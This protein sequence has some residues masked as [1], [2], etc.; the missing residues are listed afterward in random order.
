MNNR[1]RLNLKWAMQKL[2]KKRPER[3][4]GFYILGGWKSKLGAIPFLCFIYSFRLVSILLWCSNCYM[5]LE[6]KLLVEVFYLCSAAWENYRACVVVVVL[7]YFSIFYVR[8]RDFFLVLFK[9]MKQK[10]YIMKTT[11]YV[12][13]VRENLGL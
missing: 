5:L 13:E 8:I 12:R 11:W 3:N 9:W 7:C 4:V 2:W 6:K 10:Y 1:N